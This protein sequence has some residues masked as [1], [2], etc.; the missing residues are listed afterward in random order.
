MKI[1]SKAFYLGVYENIIDAAK[2]YDAK[3]IELY[4]EENIMTNKKLGLY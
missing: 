1:K 3:L 4:G 2:A